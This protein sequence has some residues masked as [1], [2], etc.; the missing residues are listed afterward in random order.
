[1]A[2]IANNEIMLTFPAN[3]TLLQKKDIL[4]EFE[5][6]IVCDELYNCPEDEELDEYDSI[7]LS[8]GTKWDEQLE[9]LEEICKKYNLSIEGVCWEF[10]CNYKSIIEINN[11]E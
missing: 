1:M 6:T 9:E 11:E 4:K 10:G 2:N 8:Y 5:N 7:E 3:L